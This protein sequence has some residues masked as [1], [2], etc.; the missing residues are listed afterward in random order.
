[1]KKKIFFMVG[2]L[3]LIFVIMTILTLLLA[4]PIIIAENNEVLNTFTVLE[5]AVF[6]ITII[7]I[8]TIIVEKKL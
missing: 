4:L 2:G 8:A 5:Y 1:M 3:T 6:T 7:V